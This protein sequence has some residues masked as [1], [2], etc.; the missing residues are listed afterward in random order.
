MQASE[1]ALSKITKEG[2]V[3]RTK[4]AIVQGIQ[5]RT[6]NKLVHEGKLEHIS[7]G[8]YRLT[9]SGPISNPDLFIIATRVPRGVIC[10]ISALSFHDITTQIPHKVYIALERRTES[11]RIEHPPMRV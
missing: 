5:S 10:L 8:I 3:I 2:G 6:L 7:R 4:D 1:R 11:P 9:S